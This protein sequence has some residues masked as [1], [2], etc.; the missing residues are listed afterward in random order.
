MSDCATKNCEAHIFMVETVKEIKTMN[1]ELM[2]SQQVLENSIIKLTENLNELHR[3]NSR[4]D[5]IMVKQ[6]EKEEAQDLQISDHRDFMNK[7]MG[8]LA[9]ATFVIPIIV[10]LI[11]SLY[12]K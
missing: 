5:H 4:I 12:F 9:V 2:R 3:M 8:S 6:N 10:S 1:L 7:A 11:V